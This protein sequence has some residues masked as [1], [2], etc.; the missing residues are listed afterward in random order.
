MILNK[1]HT[2]IL[3]ESIDSANRCSLD[4]FRLIMSDDSIRLDCTDYITERAYTVIELKSIEHLTSASVLSE[5]M[6]K[7]ITKIEYTK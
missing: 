6:G 1:Q 7:I 5:F 2:K 4:T 3:N